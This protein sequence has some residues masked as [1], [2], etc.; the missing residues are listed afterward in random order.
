MWLKLPTWK[1]MLSSEL[2][3]NWH[4]APPCA[5]WVK[6]KPAGMIKNFELDI[7]DFFNIGHNWSR[8]YLQRWCCRAARGNR[9]ADESCRRENHPG[10]GRRWPSAPSCKSLQNGNSSENWPGILGKE[11]ERGRGGRGKKNRSQT[12]SAAISIYGW[13]FPMSAPSSWNFVWS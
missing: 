5:S 6:L 7:S 13:L 11:A 1:K 3:E 9:C 10:C 8:S 4:P 2:K 12:W